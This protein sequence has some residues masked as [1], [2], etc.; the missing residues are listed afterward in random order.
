VNYEQL[1]IGNDIKSLGA[2][3]VFHSGG[4]RDKP[5]IVCGN[6]AGV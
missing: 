2:W 5:G 1:E 4:L 6:A 3:I